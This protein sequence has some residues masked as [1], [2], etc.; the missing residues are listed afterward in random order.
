MEFVDPED[1]SQV[2]REPPPPDDRLWRHPSELPA[3]PAQVGAAPK[4][5][6]PRQ[7]WFFAAASAVGASLLT[8]G[9][10][11]AVGV[12]DLRTANVTPAVERQLVRPQTTSVGVALPPVVDIA[13]RIRPAIVELQVRFADHTSTG[14]GVMFRSDGNVLT[15]FHVVDGAAAI[16]V[17]LSSGRQL[18]GRIVGADR[19]TD[20]A[21]VKID[22]GPFPIATL[23]TANDLKVGQM[24]IA[25]GSPL[26]M[27][28]G[29]SVTVGV[30]SALHRQVN[31]RVD[32]PALVD[33]VQ[34]DAPVSAGSS[35]GALL[36]D[37]GAVIGI[38]TVTTDGS[39]EGLG[40]ATPIDVARSAGDE[41]IRSGHVVHVWL[42]VEGDDL[43]GATAG[44]LNLDGGA[45]V[46]QV[47]AGGPAQQAGLNP[48]DVIV[49]VNG[50]TVRSMGELVVA[51]R[52]RAPGDTVTLEVMRDRQHK[53]FNVLLA[54]RPGS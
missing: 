7:M 39:A 38:T 42:G 30:V 37:D 3:R 51:L 33:M 34:T 28:G 44:A 21:V 14:S 43:D 49:A 6:R 4:G 31:S 29:P 13:D 15:N 40:F 41:L 50:A 5:V 20:T 46:A 47:T 48:N 8:A 17:M 35:G 26:G 16:N 25:I 11:A 2:F 52:G 36:D 10:I 24:A 12:V 54:P 22:G 18:A 32:G 1:G 53:T 45:V 27:A 19:D 9:L 23:G